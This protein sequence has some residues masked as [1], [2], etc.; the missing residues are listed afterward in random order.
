M[1]AQGINDLRPARPIVWLDEIPCFKGEYLL[2]LTEKRVKWAGKGG[3]KMRCRG[4]SK[5]PLITLQR[6]RAR[7][8]L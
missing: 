4:F 6:K 3:A 5:Y 8:P 2:C 1:K 7:R